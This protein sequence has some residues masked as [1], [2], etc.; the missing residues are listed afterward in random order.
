A[1]G[2]E[3]RVRNRHRDRAEAF[4]NAESADIPKGGAK[5][6][7]PIEAVVVVEAP[8]LGRDEGIL[9][10]LRNGGKRDVDATNY[11][12]PSD[13][14]PI[15]IHDPATLARLKGADRRRRRATREATGAE[16][17]VEAPDE[18]HHDRQRDHALPLPPEPLARRIGGT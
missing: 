12:E 9:D 10:V 7:A 18:Q 5:E 11:F 13:E 2:E 17:D 16:P 1:R 4:T 15:A 6:G 3:A 14:L 8:V